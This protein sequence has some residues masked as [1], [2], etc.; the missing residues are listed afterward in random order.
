MT[1]LALLFGTG[2]V[3]GTAVK[4]AVNGEFGEQILLLAMNEDTSSSVDY[5]DVGVPADLIKRLRGSSVTKLCVVGGVDL[6][7]E[8]RSGIAQYLI[9]NHGGTFD[10]SDMGLELAVKMI[11]NDAQVELVGIHQLLPRLLA[12]SGVISGQMPESSNSEI[13]NLLRTSRSIARTD[14]GQSTVFHGTRPLATEDALG[15]D[16]LIERAGVIR[17]KLNLPVSELTLVK[18]AKPQQSGIGDLPTVGP[19][20]IRH[21][22]AA[23]IGQ[24]I[25]EADK[26]L[27]AERQQFV[28][29]AELAEINVLGWG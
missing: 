11:A 14:I 26:C 16:S 18:V 22:A 27:I 20:T 25:V 5:I 29:A 17:K 24:I 3:A 7:A 4:A 13:D 10:A 23:G 19:I 28:E 8:R 15:T 9:E 21:C 2:D 1:K 6:P 12:G